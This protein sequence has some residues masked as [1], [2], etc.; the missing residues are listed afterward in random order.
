MFK[1][2]CETALFESNPRSSLAPPRLPLDFF[3]AT[4]LLALA[5]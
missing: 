3:A 1:N 5:A 2:T 4:F